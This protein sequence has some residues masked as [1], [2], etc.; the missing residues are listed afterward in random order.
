MG[1]NW[2]A[3]TR[4][5]LVGVIAR[6]NYLNGGASDDREVEVSVAERL[7]VDGGNLDLVGR[8]SGKAAGEGESGRFGND[9]RNAEDEDDA[10]GDQ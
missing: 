10:Y 9:R 5:R 4:Y 2:V 6:R 7:T 8:I 1:M 3:H